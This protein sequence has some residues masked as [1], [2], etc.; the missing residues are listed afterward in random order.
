MIDPISIVIHITPKHR[1]ALI[2]VSGSLAL[3]YFI[4]K[5]IKSFEVGGQGQKKIK[6]VRGK[7]KS[8][9]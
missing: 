7:F 3:G 1:K 6:K 4:Y 2:A 8:I 5:V 9:F